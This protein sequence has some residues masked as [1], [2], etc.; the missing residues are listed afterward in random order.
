MNNKSY[1]EYM[2]LISDSYRGIYEL[3]DP[4]IGNKSYFVKNYLKNDKL[5][6]NQDE[7]IEKILKISQIKSSKTEPKIKAEYLLDNTRLIL[8]L[9]SQQKPIQL[10]FHY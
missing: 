4:K 7:K 3:L 5:I 10:I 2:N 9:I 8:D 1:L 6:T